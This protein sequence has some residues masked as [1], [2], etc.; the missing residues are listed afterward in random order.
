MS[1]RAFLD[2]NVIV[3]AHDAASPEKRETAQAILF[4]GLRAGSAVLSAQVLN[5]FYVT[6]TRK[7]ATPL[8]VALA[9]REIEL[10]SRLRVVDVDV[11]L[12][13]RGIDIGERWQLSH[14]DGLIIAAAERAGCDTVL[15]EDLSDG[16]TYGSLIVRNPFAGCAGDSG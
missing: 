7:I 4:D 3:Y 8:S 1:G 2:T 11:P 13:V 15:S 14:W 9:R 10:L 6:V 12:V 5:E 16:Q